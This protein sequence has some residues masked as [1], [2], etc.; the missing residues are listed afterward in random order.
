M[1]T[2]Y[3]AGG[4]RRPGTNRSVDGPEE[5]S[6]PA[7]PGGDAIQSPEPHLWETHRAPDSSLHP[8]R[9]DCLEVRRPVQQLP[10]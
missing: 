6:R 8:L 4:Q 3:W 5:Q 7:S 1:A 2:A 10:E 9:G